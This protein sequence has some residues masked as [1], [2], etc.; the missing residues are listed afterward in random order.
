MAV[1]HQPPSSPPVPAPAQEAV[2][3]PVPQYSASGRPNTRAERIT[4]QIWVIM[5]LLVIV[6]TLINY[7][8]G[9]L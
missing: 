9:W 6:V 5:F 7:L 4:F 3:P 1:S 8:A 2:Y